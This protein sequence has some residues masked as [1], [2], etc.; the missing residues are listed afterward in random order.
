MGG[1]IAN[2]SEGN[3]FLTNTIV[4]KNTA[5]F[6]ERDVYGSFTS[7]GFNL[8]EDPEAATIDEQLFIG[9]NITGQDPQ[10]GPL[11]S[12][13]G[14]TQTHRLLSGSPAID[15]G[16][17][18]FG[19]SND[20]RGLQ[21]PVDQNSY[22]NSSKGDASDIGAFEAQ[23]T[24]DITPPSVN[25]QKASG[26]ADPAVSSP[27]NFTVQFSEAVNGF[28]ASDVILSGT[29]NPTTAVVTGSGSTYNVAVSGMTT[30]GTVAMQVRANAV[31]DQVGNPTVASNQ[32]TVTYRP[33]PTVTI[34]QA[35][36]QAD[37]AS[38]VPINFTVVF[39]EVV[40]GF[41]P[42]DV[43]LSGTANANTI[44]VTGSG[45]TYNVAVSNVT[46]QSGT[47]VASVNAG[48][49]T[50]SAGFT[51]LASTSTDNTVT[52]SGSSAFD[53]VSQ[54]VV[55]TE[56]DDLS[57]GECTNAGVGNGCTL[58]EAI[59]TANR[60]AGV[61]TILFAI[62]GAG[63]HTIELLVALPEISGDLKIINDTGNSITIHRNTSD[64]RNNYRIFLVDAG[65]TV[66]MSNLIL[67]NGV[68]GVQGGGGIRNDGTLVLT[69]M[70]ITGNHGGDASDNGNG[71]A[72]SNYGTLTVI[73]ST[74]SGNSCA[75]GGALDNEATAFVTNST[76]SDNTAR[77]GGG[78]F[79][80]SQ[81]ALTVTNS[82]V[83]NNSASFGG[84]G[85]LNNGTI[86]LRGAI[87]GHNS[88]PTGPDIYG[89]PGTTSSEGYNL[90]ETDPLGTITDT[91]NAGTDVT[92]VDP[93]L[94]PLGFYGG[95]TPTHAL[96]LSSPALD[97]GKNFATN[98][99][100]NPILTDQRGFIRPF[101]LAQV[102]AQNGDG[103]DIGAFEST[104]PLQVTNV[105]PNGAKIVVTFQGV[106]THVYRIERSSSLISPNWA[107]IPNVGNVT[108]KTDGSGQFT[109]PNGGSLGHAVYR[110]QFVR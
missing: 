94:Y 59:T 25:V 53:G 79:H 65:T 41:G 61:E 38:A 30:N 99:L 80:Q 60:D 106:A 73:G 31:T 22:P 13:G 98:A 86:T 9:T 49:A 36:G 11:A 34:D 33:Y 52:L 5:P 81:N 64:P 39:S 50:N 90:I 24:D 57:V 70:W 104:G 77:S 21:R 15:N 72:V 97:K 23:T 63:P 44:T 28:D 58:R 29:A 55:T 46:D 69:N 32:V 10:L 71:G 37:P 109:D 14:P 108:A 56:I 51:N 27:V 101:D 17:S 6:G 88:A 76:I 95:V 26:Q 1:G 62:P 75:N 8:I 12:N 84:G 89:A 102:N 74:F 19:V 83:A 100:G 66:Q 3:F 43:T 48:G 68:G 40:T 54:L 110:L 45:T 107:S 92:G 20:Q 35:T 18:L 42:S 105:A 47:I 103:S 2:S 67:T 93:G 85:I 91:Q 16:D 78:I 82:T 87:L 96:Y 7:H 4:A